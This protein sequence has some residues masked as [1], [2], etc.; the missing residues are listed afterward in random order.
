VKPGETWKS[1][2]DSPASAAYPY[3]VEGENTLRYVGKTKVGGVKAAVVEF[4]FVDVMRPAPDALGK[5]EPL[6]Q[7][8]SHG[9]GVDMRIDS[10]GKG[11]VL[12]AIH[13]GGCSRTMP[14]PPDL[15]RPSQ[16]LG[17]LPFTSSQTLKL[18]VQSDTEMDVEGSGR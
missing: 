6:A 5:A 16:W 15:E 11:R 9:L 10:Q 8:E 18:E 1:K 13:D 4:S 3:K 7:L 14:H 12:L 17:P 2:L